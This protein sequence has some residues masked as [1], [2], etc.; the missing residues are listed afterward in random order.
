MARLALCFAAAALVLATGA[1]AQQLAAGAAALPSQRSIA[2]L[3]PAATR[4][5]PASTVEPA[6]ELGLSRP[7]ALA[8][9]RQEGFRTVT[10]LVRDSEGNWIGAARRG[11]RVV[12]IA[13]D[14]DGDVIAW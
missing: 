13:V 8:R 2:T 4:P 5:A 3:P 11:N 10:R 7:E 9:L 12:A 14:N 1:T 6:I